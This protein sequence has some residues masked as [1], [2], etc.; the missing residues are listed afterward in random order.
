MRQFLL[1]LSLFALCLNVGAQGA[2]VKIPPRG[3]AMSLAEARKTLKADMPNKIA[4]FLELHNQARA[5]VGVPLAEWDPELAEFAQSWADHLVK[6]GGELQ[7]SDSEYGENLATYFP[8]RGER[9][10]HGAGLW[11]AEHTRYHGGTLTEANWEK[12]GHYTQMVWKRSVHIG[13]GVAL[14]P[15]GK[16]ILVASYRSPGNYLG[17]KPY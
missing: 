17:E 2:K 3:P 8:L 14:T 5:E 11:Y 15:Q 16:A 7:H 6:A 1:L 12:V 13:F 10:V 9:P 4:E